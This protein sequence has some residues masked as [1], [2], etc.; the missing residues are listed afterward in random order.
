MCLHRN[1]AA[2][3]DYIPDAVLER[4][5]RG[6]SADANLP[7]AFGDVADKRTQRGAIVRTTAQRLP[8]RLTT[9]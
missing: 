6:V 1:I 4:T 8:R 7:R 3:A 9:V 5:G 2:L